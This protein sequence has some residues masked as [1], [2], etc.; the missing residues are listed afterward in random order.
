MNKIAASAVELSKCIL[1][2]AYSC[3][4]ASFQLRENKQKLHRFYHK[5]A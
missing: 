1:F 3:T 2:H 5:L 4:T